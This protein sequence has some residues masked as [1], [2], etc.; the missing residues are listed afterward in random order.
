MN[1][2]TRGVLYG[3][4][5]GVWCLTLL[6]LYKL[7]AESDWFIGSSLPA[8]YRAAVFQVLSAR[9]QIA[10]A[11]AILLTPIVLAW[12]WSY[13]E[14]RMQL[15]PESM[16]TSALIWS[17]RA[18]ANGGFWLFW[19][20]LLAVT[21]VVAFLPDP[22]LAVT[23]LL[24]FVILSR[25][26]IS[27]D[28]PEVARPEWPGLNAL[29]SVIVC[30]A[31][32]ALFQIA[33]MWIGTRSVVA[34]AVV[35]PIGLTIGSILTAAAIEAFVFRMNPRT[36]ITTLRQL[37]ALRRIGP[38]LALQARAL[39][40]AAAVTVPVVIVLLFL[41]KDVPVAASWLDRHG[42][43]FPAPAVVFIH[44]AHFL[45]DFAG[46]PLLIASTLLTLLAFGRLVW[47]SSRPNAEIDVL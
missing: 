35:W 46:M 19:L 3:A 43:T 20:F 17:M 44:L 15:D 14:D 25:R 39:Y 12:I 28:R 23:I 1:K 16:S 11:A 29:L 24:P 38:V 45:G 41:W 10:V 47:L 33:L 40:I 6:V 8:R 22:A 34:G 21:V 30:L 13:V 31:I 4:A 2:T 27:S 37:I 26:L 18:T 32:S 5:F 7:I 9:T 36:R 42:Q